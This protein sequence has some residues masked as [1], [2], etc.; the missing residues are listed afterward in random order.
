MTD[1]HKP[2]APAEYARR[3]AAGGHYSNRSHRSIYKGWTWTM[4]SPTSSRSACSN[5]GQ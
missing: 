4:P 3:V 1:Y 5:G 2:F